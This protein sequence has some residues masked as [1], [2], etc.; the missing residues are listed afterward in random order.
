MCA[1]AR[2]LAL[3][4]LLRLWNLPAHVLAFLR[5]YFCVCVRVCVCVCLCA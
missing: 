5:A 3:C 2:V 1:V 4:L